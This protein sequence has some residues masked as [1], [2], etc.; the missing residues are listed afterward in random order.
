M[1]LNR[2]VLTLLVLLVTAGEAIAQE[3]RGNISASTPRFVQFVTR[4]NF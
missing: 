4:F 1:N 3:T 2:S